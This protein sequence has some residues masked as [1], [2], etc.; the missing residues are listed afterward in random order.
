MQLVI[1]KKDY[2]NYKAGE[3]VA[4]ENNIAHGLIEKGIAVLYTKGLFRASR[5]KMMRAERVSPKR[6]RRSRYKIK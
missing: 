4:V 6:K 2:K 1:F 3:I 5:D